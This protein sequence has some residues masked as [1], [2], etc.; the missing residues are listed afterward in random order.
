MKRITR[1]FRVFIAS[2]GDVTIERDLIPKVIAEIN[3]II[4]EIAPEKGVLLDLIRWE[5]HAHPGLGADA[6]DVINQQLPDYDIF[7]GI[8]WRRFGTPTSRAGSGTEEEYLRAFEK[9]RLDNQFPVLF[10]FSQ[11][12]ITIPN[13]LV[14]LE[15]LRKL[16]K[17]KEDMS[18][19]GLI[20]EYNSPEEFGDILR[21]HLVMTLSKLLNR[22][23]GDNSANQP[24]GKILTTSDM[25]LARNRVTELRN[26]YEN[27]RKSM[28]ASDLRTSKMSVIES[29]MRAMAL[30]LIPLLPELTE[31]NFA[32]DRLAAIAGLKEIPSRDYLNW[33]ANRV[34]QAESS[35]IGFHACL[36]LLKALPRLE[37]SLVES[38]V[39]KAF[40][41]LNNSSY[42]DPNQ[43]KILTDALK[44]AK[45]NTGK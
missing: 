37:R 21:P 36:A 23:K 15:Q 33:L 35:F 8:M 1:Q 42:Q 38:S 45:G 7:I 9:W 16:V 5:T 40:E 44:K 28:P 30:D 4:S 20:W 43:K 11:K 18:K 6:Q 39:H 34:G 17:F 25:S 14:E 26:D 32:G 13:S 19:K 29:K 31:S 27:L 3:L 12:N 41:R 2:P 22:D 24:T 10:Y